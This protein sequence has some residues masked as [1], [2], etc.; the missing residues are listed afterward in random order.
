MASSPADVISKEFVLR[1]FYH[2]GAQHRDQLMTLFPAEVTSKAFVFRGLN[3]LCVQDRDT[4]MA[5]SPADVHLKG[6][7]LE[8]A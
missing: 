1:G 2:V 5:L 8:R 4:L 3:S 7:Y 6:V